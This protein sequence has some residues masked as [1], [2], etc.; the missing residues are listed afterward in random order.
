MKI[1][2]FILLYV[3][4]ISE[5]LLLVKEK[6]IHSK[7]I[8]VIMQTTLKNNNFIIKVHVVTAKSYCIQKRNGLHW[9]TQMY[10]IKLPQLNI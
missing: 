8:L 9:S 1:L 4:R 5:L 7:N 2:L 3:L 10:A 6:I